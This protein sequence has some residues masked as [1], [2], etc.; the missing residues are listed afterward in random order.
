MKCEL[1]IQNI[2]QYFNEGLVKLNPETIEHLSGCHDCNLYLEEQKK[3]KQTLD[4]I[5]N[6][7]P[8]LKDPDGLTDDIMKGLKDDA[9]K[10]E[11]EL[12][13]NPTSLFQNIFFRRVLSAAAIIL[14]ALFV[15]EQYLVL[16]K[17]NRLE[18]KYKNVSKTKPAKSDTYNYNSWEFRVLRNYNHIKA[19]NKDLIEMINSLGS[20]VSL[21]ELVSGHSGK[22]AFETRE[23][24]GLY[25]QK[26]LSP[27][28]QE[29][30]TTLKQ[31]RYEN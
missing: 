18:I 13:V 3:A 31:H 14:F 10:G 21:S 8:V 12:K 4:H 19:N 20:N 26:E 27:S 24:I 17:V 15:Y 23:I 2:D 25:R 1:A 22:Y 29:Y 30:I 9:S 16:D 11:A 7:E 28:L 6:F 5:I